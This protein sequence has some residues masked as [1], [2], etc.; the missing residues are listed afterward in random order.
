MLSAQPESP[1]QR[2]QH[3]SSTKSELIHQIS[4]AS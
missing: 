1:K 2:E 3:N 4:P